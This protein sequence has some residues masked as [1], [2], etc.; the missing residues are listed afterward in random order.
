LRPL[1]FLLPVAFVLA[2][3]VATAAPQVFANDE[4]SHSHLLHRLVERERSPLIARSDML[5]SILV[6]RRVP[7]PRK[8]LSAPSS[9]DCEHARHDI[10]LDP[11]TGA[12]KGTFELR[13]R[14]VGAALEM[15]SFALDEGLE[16][17]SVE[18]TGRKALPA[19]RVFA[20]T[21]V[22]QVTLAP[23]LEPGTTTVLT[24]PYSGN[25]SCAPAENGA[26]VCS[27]GDGFSYFA[28][29][30]IFPF[31][32][33]PESPESFSLDGLTRDLVLRVPAALDVV[34]TGQKVSEI[35]DGPTKIST[36]S[37]DK[38]LSRVV[39]LYALVGKLGQK[40]VEGRSVPTTYVFPTPEKAIDEELVSWSAP[41]LDFVEKV[42]G[43]N[44]P[45][46]R[47]LSLVRLPQTIGDP[48]T[49]T[50]G[51]TLLSDSY[52]KMGNLMYEETWAH[53]NAH[54]F[55]GIVV[56]EADSLE[57]RLMSEG[58]ATL[59]E[60]DYTYARH[61]AS[62]DRDLYLARRFLPMGLDIRATEG[63]LPPVQIPWGTPVP[64]EFRTQRYT[65]WAYY[66][67]AA[68]LDHLRVMLGEDVFSNVLSTYV[69]R[70]SFVGC[71][72]DALRAIATEKSGKDMQ[73]FFDRWITGSEFPRVLV[74]FTPV[75]GGADLELTKP[76]ERPMT[77]E[78]WL[79]LADGTRVKHRVDLE[80]RTSRLH[81][82]TPA[83][84]LSVQANPRHD[85][86]VDVR[87]AVEGDLDFDGETDG[88]DVLRCARLVGRSYA[89]TG[90][91]G[92]WNL[93][94]TFDTRCDVNGD[95]RIDDEDLALVTAQFGRL[96]AR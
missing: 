34:A 1:T 45:F 60:L 81:L 44:L 61:F 96:R 2:P 26:V 68:A 13:V 95:L 48:G 83:T 3:S 67:S 94:E 77:L 53:E 51:M 66:K 63:E 75:S 50:F 58:M 82:D 35:I 64:H 54:L 17:E 6:P 71:R 72:P 46:D 24:V 78:L 49:A 21:R 76:D 42:A 28:Q 30:S 56:P 84:V 5:R 91:V 86:L 92:L 19:T 32:F 39:G 93:E 57:S 11:M 31:V 59:S 74:G 27:K 87:S 18:A 73:P 41:A 43:T 23:P 88:F 14:A 37:I 22:V 79:G 33:D 80:R 55:W 38:P 47:G 7:R 36:W 10:T 65:L 52:M 69:A 29:Q 25:L 15:I 90:A 40:R 9:M 70:C 20:P 62:E 4:V 85:L 8:F 12:T 89:S 16:V